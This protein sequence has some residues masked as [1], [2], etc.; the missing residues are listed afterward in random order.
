MEGRESDGKWRKEKG[1]EGQ[2]RMN[3]LIDLL[4]IIYYVLIVALGEGLCPVASPGV[5]ARGHES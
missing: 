2:K 1:G 4:G 5:V 3:R